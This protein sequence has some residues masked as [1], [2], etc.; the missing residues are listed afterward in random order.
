ML[1][2]R[3]V[4][5]LDEASMIGSRQLAQVI[6]HCS[7]AG[8]TLVLCGDSRQ[9]QAIELGGLFTELTRR[10]DTSH[11]TDI[12]RQRETW[13]RE[14][15]K[16]F[17]FGR[18]G[19]ALLPYQQRGF[20][21]ETRHEI[22][23]M[24][25]MLQ[26]WKREALPDLQ[27][28]LMLAGSSADVRELNR[29][30]QEEQRHLGLLGDTPVTTGPDPIFTGD[31]VLFTRNSLTLGVANGDLGKVQS[32]QGRTLSVRMDD[33]RDVA[34]PLD[35]YSHLRLGYALTTHKAQGMTVERAFILAGGVMADRELTYVQASR[36]RGTTRWYVG[37]DL[38]EVTQRMTRSH[39]KLAAVSLTEGPE[40]ELTLVR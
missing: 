29:R 27:G 1:D 22:T 26:D 6:E 30:A 37:H 15:V 40:L 3:S 21:T 35:G 17:A 14:S 2:D 19:A 5:V 38:D 31:R 10:L 16:H 7:R 32:A 13:A 18:A 8:A 4:V 25:R 39:E 34:V 11:L 9:L 20:L 23:A 28:S 24:D 36:A 12:Q 33:G